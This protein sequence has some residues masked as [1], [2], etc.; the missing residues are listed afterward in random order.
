MLSQSVWSH[1]S[2]HEGVP[3]YFGS[4]Q[5]NVTNTAD[6]EKPEMAVAKVVMITVMQ[7]PTWCGI[8]CQCDRHR[9]K[10]KNK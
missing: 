10:A 7:E 5:I 6:E 2:C 8:G 9:P 3:W 1:H 4:S